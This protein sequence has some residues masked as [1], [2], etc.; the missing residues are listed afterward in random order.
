M[1]A[2][3]RMVYL[4]H[5]A[6]T[7]VAPECLEVMRSC[8]ALGPIN[9]SSKHSLGERARLLLNQAREKVASA[10]G[11][12][13]SEVVFTASGTESNHLAI[14]G[15]LALL[16]QR[17]HV[18]TTAVEHPST[19]MLMRHLEAQGV[20]V[21][22]LPV[23]PAGKLIIEAL[24]DT[25]SDG[26]ALV[27]VMWANNE[28]GVVFPVRR[29]AELARARGAL[30][31]T[32]AVQAAGKLPIDLKSVP[33]DLLSMSGHKLYAPAGVGALLVRKG[34]K[35]PPLLFGHQE[36]GRRGGTENLAGIAAL[37]AA[38]ALA[39]VGMSEESSRLQTLRDRL[40]RGVL[41]VVPDARVNG[42]GAPRIANTSSIC[43]GWVEAEWI[44]GRLDRQG[45]YASAGAACASGETKPSHVLTAMGL[46]ASE[47]LATVR[48]SLGRYNTERDIDDLLQ[49]LPQVLREL[50][51]SDA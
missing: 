31:H 24:E 3:N 7:A 43:F 21:T 17:R 34:V 49:I 28:T 14:L 11:A 44:L 36:R 19:L 40:E 26:T 39:G 47:A 10:F 33:V 51:L 50:T 18:I 12:T 2:M 46:R 30:F 8:L 15:A 4:D 29:A 13:A 45:I 35:L 1:T 48:F 9:P 37:G 41:A 6:S 20:R 16:P 5:N 23:D 42:A 38:C 22:Y 32:D 27:S 25:L